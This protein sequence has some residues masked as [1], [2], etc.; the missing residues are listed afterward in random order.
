MTTLNIHSTVTLN[1]GVKMPWLGLG[2]YK[3]EDGNEV[4]NAIKVALEAGYRSID[5]ASFYHNE[6]GV[7]EALRETDVPR[8]E[9]FVT[10][11]VWNDEQGYEETLKAFESSRTKLGL[12]VID[13][14]LVHWPVTGK[15][16]DTWRAMEKLYDEGK[17]RAIGVS[18]FNIHHL[19]YLLKDAKVKPVVNQVEFHPLLTQE[20]LHE[21]CKKN[22]I[23][24]EAWSPL[25][26]GHMFDDER[27]VKLA[28]KYGKTPA[29]I[30][31]RW[32]LQKEV[33]T[34]PKSVTPARIQ[35]NTEIFDFE[36]SEEDMNI[37]DSCNEHKRFGPD[38]DTF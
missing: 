21:F 20:E 31:L 10:T 34:I 33:V 37:L 24:L 25:T 22:D 14:Y 27:L 9:I 8:E 32:D 29:Q 1:N 38:P 36:L 4:K 15:F 2:V 23:Q 12:D 3:A 30:I 35:S 28:E 18:N 26:R 11:K 17:V 6:A 7:G 16:K 13:L 5:T 19:E